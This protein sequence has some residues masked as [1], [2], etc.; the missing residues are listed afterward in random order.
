[1]EK[2]WGLRKARPLKINANAYRVDKTAGKIDTNQ[3]PQH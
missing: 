3:K 1:M 2:E